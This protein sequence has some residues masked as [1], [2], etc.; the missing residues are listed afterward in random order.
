MNRFYSIAL[1]GIAPLV[2]ISLTSCTSSET[3]MAPIQDQALHSTR[4]NDAQEEQGAVQKFLLS[5]RGDID[6]LILIGGIQVSFPSEM[7]AQVRRV[8]SLNSVVNVKGYYENDRV[9]KAE[10]ITNLDTSKSVTEMVSPPP[11]PVQDELSNMLPPEGTRSRITR[12]AG[13]SHKGLKKLSAQGR[14][15]NRLY[16]NLGELTGVILSDGTI[17]KFRPDVINTLDLNT[18]IG[19]ELKASGYGVQNANGRVIDA[20]EVRVQ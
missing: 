7:S 3:R 15:E 11:G 17:V 12:T 8:V 5:S 14:V 9:F 2:L 13:P 4:Y 6:G 20:T 18:Q 19:D 16:G 10:R 1:V